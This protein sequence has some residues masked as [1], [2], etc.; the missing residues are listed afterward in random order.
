MS[1]WRRNF[2]TPLTRA[3]ARRNWGMRVRGFLLPAC[4]LGLA[5]FT[6]PA[7]AFEVRSLDGYGNNVAN[8]DWGRAGTAY[9]RLAP[10]RYAD[11]IGT[12]AGGPNT[13]YLSNRVFN[14]RTSDIFS[15]RDVSQW[16]WTWGQFIDHTFGLAQES[17]ESRPI[18]FAGIGADGLERFRNDLGSIPFRRD[19]AAAGTGDSP[20]APREQLNTVSSYLDGWAVYGGTRERL[21]WLRDGPV[22]GT[23]DNNEPTLMLEP[24]GYLPRATARGNPATAP[25]MKADGRLRGAPQNAV[26][27]GDVRANQNIALT[28]IHTLFARE[29]NRIVR[30]LPP[31]LP[32]E[33]RFEIA[34]RI[35]SAEQQ[36]VTYKE[37]LP[38]V[39][40]R[41]PRYRGYD[42]TVN[43]S[44]TN[45]FATVGYRAHSMVHQEFEFRV[46]RRE[47]SVELFN[48]TFNPDLV[49]ELGLGNVLAGLSAEAQYRND[50]LIDDNLRSI[51]FQIPSAAGAFTSVLDLGAI[52]VERGRDHGMPTY[53]E[54]R[55]AVGLRPKAKFREITGERSERF[56]RHLRIDPS[57]PR[58]DR[59]DILEFVD[60]RDIAGRRFRP[61]DC[62]DNEKAD[63]VARSG[64]RR[65]PLAARLRAVY[66]SVKKLD[67]YTGML[68]EPHVR[69]SELGELQHAIWA[70]QFDALRTGD[71]F[72]YRHD[73]ALAEIR[74]RFGIDY[75]HT[76]AE[77]IALNTDAKLDELPANVFFT[78]DPRDPVI[79]GPRR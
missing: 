60:L 10:P 5:A 40:V 13:R 12:P 45:E 25:G 1:A 53:N 27:A 35:V 73:P 33:E 19:A 58:N 42:P 17:T 48:A 55:R 77:L 9:P 36:Y 43:A 64:R 78:H 31:T 51:L 46:G 59:L 38:A 14:D 54:L 6:P 29:H 49:P 62:P 47:V 37:F 24:G 16:V 23:L 7:T 30:A 18:P 50:E 63:T 72:F 68:S 71:R 41:L 61:C 20:A 44:L 74:Q 15:E 56:P 2:V 21:E 66:R 26:V 34:R 65:T 69:G 57:N 28:A 4:V 52:D 11:G 76:L 22:D 39:G 32:A 8:P 70:R 3:A 79:A 67:A 75:R